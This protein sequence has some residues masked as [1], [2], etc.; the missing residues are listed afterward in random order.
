MRVVIVGC[1][2]IC[3]LSVGSPALHASQENHINVQVLCATETK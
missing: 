2:I 3:I 1:A